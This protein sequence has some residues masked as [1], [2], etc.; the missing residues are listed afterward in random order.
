VSAYNK[1]GWSTVSPL[2][3]PIKVLST[4]STPKTPIL[5]SKKADAIDLE[6][7]P[8]TA[9]NNGAYELWKSIGGGPFTKVIET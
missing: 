5:K 7:E 6:W 8:Y 9:G 1:K 4:P 2:S 3:N